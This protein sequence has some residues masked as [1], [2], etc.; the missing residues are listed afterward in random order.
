MI[1]DV[2]NSK[3]F[4]VNEIGTKW[5]KDQ[6]ITDWA[7]KPDQF[8]TVLPEVYGFFI[9]EIG[10]R[11]TRVLINN[12]THAIIYESQL[13]EAVAVYIDV[14]KLVKRDEQRTV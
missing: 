2:W 1:D 14:L 10:G 12:T 4:F 11:K 5:W 8:G 7:Q 6:D 13:L 3:P 9:Q